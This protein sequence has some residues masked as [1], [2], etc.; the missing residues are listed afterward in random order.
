MSNMLF[1]RCESVAST[2]IHKFSQD[3]LLDAGMDRKKQ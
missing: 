1:R 2:S 3:D